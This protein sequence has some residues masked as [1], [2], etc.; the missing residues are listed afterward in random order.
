MET[1]MVMSFFAKEDW[2]FLFNCFV[3]AGLVIYCMNQTVQNYEG[4][5]AYVSLSGVH[6]AS[7]AVASFSKD[8]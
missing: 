5:W 7:S 6:K 8:K 2:I 3:T 1:E 4:V